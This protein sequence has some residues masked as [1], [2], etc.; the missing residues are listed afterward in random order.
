MFIDY[1]TLFVIDI[2]I[3]STSTA[4]NNKNKQNYIQINTSHTISLDFN[5]RDHPK[6]Q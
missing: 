3:L 2:G 6:K 5:S 4:N 1:N